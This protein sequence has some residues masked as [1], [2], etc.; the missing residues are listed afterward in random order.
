MKFWFCLE[1]IL[2]SFVT[3]ITYAATLSKVNVEKQGEKYILHVQARVF[4]ETEIVKDII[5]DFSNLP[6]INPYLKK[7]QIIKRDD[8]ST[9][10]NMLT[11]ACILIICYKINDT[12]SFR[13][14]DNETLFS[15][16]IPDMSDFKYGWYRWVIRKNDSFPEKTITEITLDSEVIPDFF[17]L[18]IIGTYHLKKKILDIA[19]ITI[20]NLE[21]TAQEKAIN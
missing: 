10:V 3:N 6:L 7:S 19:E 5:T 8:K 2:L 15:N 16:T 1:L 21:I 12:Q 17:I 11:E 13:F 9:T 14:L 20:K 4:A 18:P